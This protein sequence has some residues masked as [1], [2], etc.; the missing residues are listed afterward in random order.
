MHRFLAILVALLAAVPAAGQVTPKISSADSSNTATHIT[1]AYTYRSARGNFKTMLPRG[2]GTVRENWSQPHPDAD[3]VTAIEITHIFCDQWGKK[4]AGVSVSAIF[5]E[6][7]DD[8]TPAG[9]P[10]VMARVEEQ[11]S[12]YH[13]KVVEQKPIRRAREDGRVFEGLDVKAEDVEGQG[14]VWVRGLLQGADI[15][16]LVGWNREGGLWTDPEFQAFFNEFDL[17]E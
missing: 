5:N 13:V 6:R 8:G 9:P 3:P 10:E 12:R 4:G 16:V 1:H 15:Y 14:R 2:C 17:L 7:K 11:L